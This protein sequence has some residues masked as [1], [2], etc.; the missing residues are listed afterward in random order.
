MCSYVRLGLIPKREFLGILRA[1]FSRHQ[2]AGVEVGSSLCSGSRSIKRERGSIGELTL[3]G[4]GAL[5]IVREVLL[6]PCPSVGDQIM[7]KDLFFK[8]QLCLNYSFA[9]ARGLCLRHSQPMAVAVSP[10]DHKLLPQRTSS[11]F[12]STHG[13]AHFP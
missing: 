7:L 4:V 5:F 13:R 3:V 2:R 10:A 6:Y 12:G 11:L 8:L 9:L 1:G